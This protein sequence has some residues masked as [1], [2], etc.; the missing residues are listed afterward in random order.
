[1]T[2]RSLRLGVWSILTIF[3]YFIV[4]AVWSFILFSCAGL[5]AHGAEEFP[6]WMNFLVPLPAFISPGI[7]VAG[8][9]TGIRHWNEHRSR[10]GVVL[11]LLGIAGNALLWYAFYVLAS[12]H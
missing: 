7:G 1:M 8:L 2:N 12:T 11:S 5:G 9:V 4:T 3:P 10:L 6:L